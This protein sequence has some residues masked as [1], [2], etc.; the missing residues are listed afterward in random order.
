MLPP[1]KWLPKHIIKLAEKANL[2]R[3]YVAAYEKE[4]YRHVLAVSEASSDQ[5]NS[6]NEARNSAP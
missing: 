2:D 5:S 4:E 6:S 1:K 3:S